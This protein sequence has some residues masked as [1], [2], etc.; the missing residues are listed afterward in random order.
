MRFLKL[1]LA[2]VLICSTNWSFGQSTFEMIVPITNSQYAVEIGL[3]L[4]IEDD[5]HILIA[6]GGLV[7]STDYGWFKKMTFDGQQVFLCTS[8]GGLLAAGKHIKVRPDQS[9]IFGYEQ[10]GPAYVTCHVM[11]VS[12]NG[13]ETF[14]ETI[15]PIDTPY[16][17][18]EHS[19][20]DLNVLAN[21]DYI[22]TVYKDFPQNTL[23]FGYIDYLTDNHQQMWR[24]LIMNDSIWS[25]VRTID[26]DNSV[27]VV[28]RGIV[29]GD[30]ATEFDILN[31]NGDHID[32]ISYEVGSTVPGEQALVRND[33]LFQLGLRV[34]N[35]TSRL[36][37]IQ[38]DLSSTTLSSSFDFI[39]SDRVLYPVSLDMNGSDQFIVCYREY[40]ASGSWVYGF[41]I[42]D[43]SL[44]PLVDL[45]V[46]EVFGNAYQDRII[47]DIE[48]KDGIL[49]F[50]GEVDLLGT[51]FRRVYYAR[52]NIATYLGIGET[53]VNQPT[54]L[55]YPN[56]TSQSIRVEATGT[57][58]QPTTITITDMLGHAVLHHPSAGQ[59]QTIDISGLANGVY[60]LD[61]TLP[62][63][64][65]RR[66]RLV[67][68]R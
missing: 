52:M 23:Y 35:D 46:D 16:F 60:T 22:T 58:T 24:H 54:L 13:S 39:E 25:P 31:T 1:L 59:E 55:I 17:A 34:L 9:Y 62:N 19:F 33:T 64:E 56:P 41:M 49:H 14:D 42:L 65:T 45:Y 5:N 67:V 57:S 38:S 53:E 7:S 68:Q 50:I 44:N 20:G 63:G 2:P 40:L 3:D 6:A 12:N 36:V 21:G 37:I 15:W 51:G 29:N 66:E 26:H 43:N 18:N 8:D 4:E 30:F 28:K 11:G 47:K 10:T 27:I 61:A 48:H 32:T